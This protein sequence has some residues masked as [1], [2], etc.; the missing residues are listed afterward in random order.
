[1]SLLLP[2]Q[3]SSVTACLNKLAIVENEV[4]Y[5]QFINSLCLSGSEINDI[6][7]RLVDI[8]SRY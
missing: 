7:S 2:K 6:E 5:M 3:L 1:M 8:I 4:G